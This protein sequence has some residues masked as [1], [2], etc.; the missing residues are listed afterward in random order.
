MSTVLLPWVE[1][2]PWKQQSI[3]FSGLRGPDADRLPATKALGRWLRS[4]SQQNADPSKEYMRQ[5]ALPSPKDVTDELEALPCH[6]VHHLADSL[7]V[8]AYSHPDA[9]VRQY[10]YSVHAFIAEEIFHFLP[11][12]PEM[13]LWRHRDKPDGV[14]PAPEPPQDDRSWMDA[15]LPEGWEHF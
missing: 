12:S 6:Y 11:E 13:F 9:E 3:L 4:I 10:A 2:L 5:A 8:V 15:L 14:D 7:A 1:A